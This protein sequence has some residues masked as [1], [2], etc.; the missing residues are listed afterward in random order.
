MCGVDMFYKNRK[1][2]GAILFVI[3]LAPSGICDQGIGMPHWKASN[4]LEKVA[5]I[6]SFNEDSSEWMPFGTGVMV[7]VDSS[8]EY[9]Y[10]VTNRHVC[11]N[12]DSL[13]IELRVYSK[14]DSISLM[15][16]RRHSTVYLDS[17]TLFMPN[18]NDSDFAAIAIIRPH[19]TIGYEAI[20]SENIVHF[21]SL[22][23]GETVEFYGY[24]EYKF[25]GLSTSKFNFPLTRSGVISYFAYEDAYI[26]GKKYMISGM[27]LIDGVSYGGN[28]GAPIFVKRE[29]VTKLSNGTLVVSYDKRLAGII[30]GHLP[31]FEQGIGKD[32]II[33]RENSNL[34]TA[35]SID[36][37]IDYLKRRLKIDQ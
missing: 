26:L 30:S 13:K 35:I 4:T 28:S 24:P 16:V 14:R 1:L 19:D 29:Y 25:Y 22:I 11:I 21:D 23:Y 37:I 5:L 2:I 12:K 27:F 10:L 34:A 6:L 8:I 3:I 36:K 18:S 15:M 32:S 7:D 9:I 17:T 20:L 33:T 31:H